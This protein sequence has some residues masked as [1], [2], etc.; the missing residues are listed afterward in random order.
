MSVNIN[1]DNIDLSSLKAKPIEDDLFDDLDEP[2][3]PN[4][5]PDIN[6]IS[7]VP[8]VPNRVRSR[9]QETVNQT[10]HDVQNE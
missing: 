9:L 1:K 6:E 7:D 4:A 3:Q 10:N 2:E 5:N 8:D